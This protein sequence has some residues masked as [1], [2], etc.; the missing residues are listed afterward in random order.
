MIDCD[1]E[2]AQSAGITAVA[3]IFT[4]RCRR[5]RSGIAR[6]VRGSE[7]IRKLGYGYAR[8]KHVWEDACEKKVNVVVEGRRRGEEEEVELNRGNGGGYRALASM[9]VLGVSGCL[10]DSITRGTWTVPGRSYCLDVNSCNFMLHQ[11]VPTSIYVVISSVLYSADATLGLSYC[12][13]VLITRWSN[14][15]P[16]YELIIKKMMMPMVELSIFP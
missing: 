2:K 5:T 9:V 13:G 4:R 14:I 12:A 3:S 16:K 1:N 11:I 15:W 10:L 6:C 7:R 8:C